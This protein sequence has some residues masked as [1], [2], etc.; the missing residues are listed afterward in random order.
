MHALRNVHR[1]LDDGGLVL[2]LHPIPPRIRV[3]AE[4]R[5]LGPLD[6]RTWF[7]TVRRV[8]REL[9]KTVREGLFE[10]ETQLVFETYERY[11]SLADVHEAVEEW[12][13]ASLSKR[14]LERLRRVRPPFDFHYRL[15]LRRYRAR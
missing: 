4:G 13:G 14:L 15:T 7:R 8:E 9:D 12:E 1:L 5:D 11:P 3:H 10:L 2:D 6:A